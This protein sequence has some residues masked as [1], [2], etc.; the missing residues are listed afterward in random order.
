MTNA[1]TSCPKCKEKMEEGFI[2]DVNQGHRLVSHWVEGPPEKGL[3]FGIK[4]KGKRQKSI[5]T[6]RCTSCGYLES[7][8]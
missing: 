6:W 3:W 4:L 5:R 7:Y 8:A 2:I 1:D